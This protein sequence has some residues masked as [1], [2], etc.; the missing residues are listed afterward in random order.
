M[1]NSSLLKRSYI[2]ASDEGLAALLNKGYLKMKSGISGKIIFALGSIP[3]GSEEDIEKHYYGKS[4]VVE[5]KNLPNSNHPEEILRYQ[6][7]SFEISTPFYLT[8]ENASL[9]GSHSNPQVILPVR[10]NGRIVAQS[11]VEQSW[12]SDYLQDIL[13][14]STIYDLLKTQYSN[15]S[16]DSDSKILCP[17]IGKGLPTYSHW[18]LEYLPRLQAVEKYEQRTGREPRILV[19]RD[20]ADWQIKSIELAGI[21]QSR[22]KR[23][24][25]NFVGNQKLLLPSRYHTIKSLLSNL[26]GSD[27]KIPPY[28]SLEWLRSKFGPESRNSEYPNKIYISRADVNKN[29][30]FNTKRQVANENEVVAFL[31]KHGFQRI[32]PAEYS[33]P[34]QARLFYNADKIVFPH[35]SANTNLIFARNPDVIEIFGDK[36]TPGTLV[37]SSMVDFE[38]QY[39]RFAETDGNITIDIDQLSSIL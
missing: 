4:E 31:R 22:I 30:D 21:N 11:E 12:Q 26:H 20:T 27:Y 38:Y 10:H 2:L 17:L 18:M 15:Q 33:I 35:G 28:S 8:V 25:N 39:L 14:V 37:L 19:A 13:N 16:T 24:T 36:V 7:K 29:K 32:F 6:G 3:D 1:D 9:V 23:W 34:E 5:I